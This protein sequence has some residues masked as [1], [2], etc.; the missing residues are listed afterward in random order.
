VDVPRR[1]PSV[2]TV[3]HDGRLRSRIMLPV[4]G[5]NGIRLGPAPPC[6]QQVGVRCIPP[7]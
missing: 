5:L 2:N 1:S 7:N 3:H 6:G 4:V